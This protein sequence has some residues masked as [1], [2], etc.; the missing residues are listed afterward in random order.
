MNKQ[1]VVYWRRKWQP[2]PVLLPGESTGQSSLV[3]YS[4][5]CCKESGKLGDLLKLTLLLEEKLSQDVVCG[6]LEIII[7]V[8]GLQ[9]IVETKRRDVSAKV[10]PH[11]SYS[12]RGIFR[13]LAAWLCNTRSCEILQMV[14]LCLSSLARGSSLFQLQE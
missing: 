14:P 7:H 3:G 5:W 12:Q 10:R 4:P 8:K 13:T 11:R 2:T 1:N 6:G 9:L